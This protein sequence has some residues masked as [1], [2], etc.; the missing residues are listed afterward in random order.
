MPPTLPNAKN[1]Y[2]K[3]EK[4]AWKLKTLAKNLKREKPFRKIFKNKRFTT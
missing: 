3:K 4:Q 2:P 1:F